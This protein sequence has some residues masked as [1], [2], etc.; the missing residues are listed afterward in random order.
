MGVCVRCAGLFGIV[1]VRLVCACIGVV[2][3]CIC[4]NL[5]RSSDGW[6]LVVWR[7][8]VVV[9]AGGAVSFLDVC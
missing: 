8:V 9:V 2:T 1:G 4:F 6:L 7:S 5:V 3:V